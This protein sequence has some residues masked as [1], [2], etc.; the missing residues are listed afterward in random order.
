MKPVVAITIGDMNGIGPEIVLKAVRSRAVTSLCSPVLVGPWPAFAFY[1]KKLRIALPPLFLSEPPGRRPPAPRPGKLLAS[2]GAVAA[3]AIRHAV[4]LATNRLADAIVTAPVSKQALM[5]AGTRFPGQ[6]EFLG[7]LTGSRQV[8]MMLVC[9]SLRVGLVTIHLPVRKI[10]KVL[11]RT[12][13]QERIM[14]YNHSL[15]RDWGI[16]RP[17]IAVL[18]L[19]PHAGE[20]GLLGNE[21]ETII[22]PVLKNLRRRTVAV[23][24]PFPADAFFARRQFEQFDAVIAIYHDQGLI[25][26]KME[27]RGLGVNVSAGL[28]IIRTSPDH[29]TGFDIAGKGIAD[30]RSMIEAIKCAVHIARKRNHKR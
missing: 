11:T 16:R 20:N 24:G 29:G 13:L 30:P 15:R 14:L 26:L 2:S 22:A 7:N 19:N 1:A 3:S 5:E 9:P 21:E 23:A 4:F 10:H 17:K 27:A 18:G 12:L 6:T 28:P 8:G 25:P